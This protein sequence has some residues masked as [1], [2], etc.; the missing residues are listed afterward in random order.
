MIVLKQAKTVFAWLLVLI[1]LLGMTPFTQAADTPLTVTQV[2][3]QVDGTVQVHFSEPVSLLSRSS[4][5]YLAQMAVVL[6]N[7]NGSAVAKKANGTDDAVW[8]RYTANELKLAE[9][10]SYVTFDWTVSPEVMEYVHNSERVNAFDHDLR[11]G[12][13]LFDLSTNAVN[14]LVDFVVAKSD[15]N[16][17]LTANTKYDNK[18]CAL[19]ADIQTAKPYL[20][21]VTKQAETVYQFHFSKP[22]S[23]NL[24]ANTGIRPALYVVN[25]ETG[26]VIRQRVAGNGTEGT[27]TL[28]S[29][30]MSLL[31]DYKKTAITDVL[32]YY[33]QNKSAYAIQARILGRSG[34]TDRF[35]DGITDDAGHS[36]YADFRNNSGADALT[37]DITERIYPSVTIGN[38]HFDTL[39]DALAAAVAGNTVT[40][41]QDND[42]RDEIVILPA[43]VTLDLNG[44]TLTAPQFL[45]FGNVIDSKDGRGLLA[46]HRNSASDIVFLQ[47]ENTQLPLYDRNADGYRFFVYDIINKGSRE[48]MTGQTVTTVKFGVQLSFTNTDAYRILQEAE[49]TDI[50]LTLAL[51][52]RYPNSPDTPIRYTFSHRTLSAYANAMLNGSGNTIVLKVNGI[53]A[54]ADQMQSMPISTTLA[55]TSSVTSGT[56][57]TH[58]ATKEEYHIGMTEQQAAVNWVRGHI[59]DKDLISFTYDG[60]PANLDNWS[61]SISGQSTTPNADWTQIRTYKK[62]GITLTIT[63]S[64]RHE[65]AAL[66]WVADWNYSG[67]DYSKRISNVRILNAPFTIEKAVMT[68]ANQGGQ[69]YVYDYQPYS[70][71]LTKTSTYTMQNDGGRS[72]Q[73]AWPYFDLTSGYDTYGIMGAIGW[74]GNWSCEFVYRNGSVNVSA[75]MQNTDYQMK[76]GE[77]LRTPSMVIQFFKGTQE[78]GHNAW[79][80]LVLDAYTPKQA[81]S[82]QKVTYAPISI[83]TWGGVGTTAL[84]E[85]MNKA[86]NSGQYFEYQWVDAGW[87]GDTSSP[88]S[89]SLWSDQVG[90]WY[91]NP[92]FPAKSGAAT[93]PDNGLYLTAGG[94]DALKEWHA[95][96]G[97]GL[98]VWFEPGRATATSRMGESATKNNPLT[99]TA[100]Y[101]ETPASTPKTET[102]SWNNSYFLRGTSNV[103]Y[104][105]PEA[106]RFIRAVVLHYLDDMGCTIYR[107]DYNFNPEKGWNNE[108][109]HASSSSVTRTGIAE[110]QYVMGHY[111][112][113]DSILATGRLIDNCASGGRLLDI[114]MMKRSIPLWRTDY[115]V[116]GTSVASGIRSQGANLSWWLPISGASGSSQ[117]YNNAYGFRSYMA[118]GATMGSLMTDSTF[119]AKMLNEMRTNRE[120]ML[121]DYYILQQGLHEGLTRGTDTGHGDITCWL[122]ADA[123]KDY[124]DSANAAYEFYR[125]DLGKGYVV[126]FRPT[127]SSDDCDTLL[128]KGLDGHA[129]Y[130]IKD[131]D[132][133]ETAVYSGRFLMK[134]GLKLEFPTAKTALMIYFTRK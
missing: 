24:D 7:K 80:Q 45:S 76:N 89:S 4:D 10:G 3:E 72:S 39:S 58:D 96:N 19:I 133:G 101:K 21:G 82:D 112:L 9:D 54:L 79:R 50:T 115:T 64:F 99:F 61:E 130:E 128:L 107:Q 92:D 134:Q 32:N 8:K 11:Y 12:F 1:L 83:N 25:K 22:I 44:Y 37:W 103:H 43:G 38:T 84:L 127:Y 62:D 75:G 110:I 113:L 118:S 51:T 60:T 119:A 85:T 87:Y 41:Y 17:K 40:L 129:L 5:G 131:A 2:V 56:G 69:N 63:V 13:I 109:T 91:Y 36:A 57:M 117:G 108:D 35:V 126:A 66:E 16:K 53:D 105:K 88:A 31:V 59:I 123:S 23:A 49:N 18:D 132:S 26:A 20:L 14:G 67:S 104:G 120:L 15:P 124:T 94:F 95:A 71:D 121:G 6:L 34:D 74:T 27:A 116:S 97:T 46:N 90:N 93:D 102:V 30:R 106:L 33:A 52:L 86:K 78:D 77:H 73:G 122:E 114:E 98:I 125:E 68:T 81:Y 28:S 47:Q 29:D 111:E 70:V 100:T 55:A 65:H 48:V 42:C